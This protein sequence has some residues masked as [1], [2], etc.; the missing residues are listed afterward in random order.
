M[1]VTMFR[2]TPLLCGMVLASLLVPTLAAQ[3]T[4]PKAPAVDDDRREMQLRMR[5]NWNPHDKEAHKQLDTI[6]DKKYA[7]R[8]RME[9]NGNW[10]RNNPNDYI[11]ETTMWALATTI[12]DPEYAISIDHFVLANADRS[13][14][15]DSY[16]SVSDQLAFLLVDRGRYAE[17][18]ALLRR[19]TELSPTDAGV[20][21]NLADAQKKAG[22]YAAAIP[23]YRKSLDLDN[24]QESTHEGLADVLMQTGDI[25][26]CETEM[27]ATIAIYNAQYHG[28][29]GPTDSFHQMIKGLVNVSKNDPVLAKLHMKLARAFL[30]DK[31]FDR[32]LAEVDAAA[33]IDPD[34][35]YGYFRAE[36]YD[37]ER[38]PAKASAARNQTSSAI[39]AEAK[40]MKQD[41]FMDAFTFPQEIFMMAPDED[42]GFDAPHEI[43]VL[44]EPL[45]ST[46]KLKPGDQLTLGMAYCSKG[47]VNECR[48]QVETGLRLDAKLN[49]S[50]TQYALAQALQK[51]H[52]MAGA[53]LHF[54]KAYEL[55]PLNTTYRADYEA[56]RQH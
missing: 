51:N 36:I 34:S 39:I 2:S 31:D 1:T 17:A 24:N 21:A 6:L 11:A 40:K 47:R 38:E 8:S 43:I 48:Q 35:P 10:L 23:S 9:E 12:Q 22:Q 16:D 14:D 28:S 41:P 46:G 4:K 55:E 26:G 15:P 52:D 5:L 53:Q 37:A 25:Q 44:L 56:T 18:L 13:E 27:T 33:K 42:D 32:A 54:Q 7:F 50:R 20:W 29:E 30:A 19:S 49:T 45:V 3:Q